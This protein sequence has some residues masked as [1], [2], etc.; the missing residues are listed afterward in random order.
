ML[1]GNAMR[2]VSHEQ[3]GPSRNVLLGEAVQRV[4][5]VGIQSRSVRG[6]YGCL[7]SGPRVLRGSGPLLRG[8]EA[9]INWRHY[10]IRYMLILF[11]HA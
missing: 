10:R 8:G 4:S 11:G 1:P 7:H 2:R 5:R 9:S 6:G 3:P